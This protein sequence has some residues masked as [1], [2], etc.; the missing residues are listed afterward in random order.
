MTE[1]NQQDNFKKLKICVLHGYL[2]TG[3]GSNIFVGNLVRN[4]C[5]LGHDVYLFCQQTY[6]EELDYIHQYSVF[7]KG[8]LSYRTV[9]T[10]DTPFPGKCYL[11]NPHIN[12][13]LPVYVFDR[14]K[15]FAV[16]TFT[17][18]HLSEVD[19][20]IA[21]NAQAVETVHKE[22]T[23]DLIQSNHA[24][25]SPYIAREVWKKH[26]VPYYI[27]IHGSALNF[28]LKKDSRFMP[29]AESAF[30]DAT[31][32]FAVSSHNRLEAITFFENIAPKI[33]EK[34]KV[35]PAGVD[36]NLFKILKGPKK[37][38]IE[39]LKSQ[40]K[41]SLEVLPYGKTVKQKKDFVAALSQ[42]YSIQEI[43][44]LVFISNQQYEQGHPDQDVIAI[45]D[46][47]DWEN[48]RVILFVGKYLW[49]K[50]VQM[51]ISSLP[52]VLKYVPNVHLVLVGFGSYREELEALSHSL[53]AGRRELFSH[54][55]EK[56]IS[57]LNSEDDPDTA[58]PF[59]FLHTLSKRKKIQEYFDLSAD[60]KISEHV[61]FLGALSHTELSS[62]LPCVDGF[63]AASV[64]PEAFGMVSIEALACGVMPTVSNQTG[65]KE[66]VDLISDTVDTGQ[67]MPR[68][69]VNMD[70]IFTIGTNIIQNIIMSDLQ[71]NRFKKELRQL[72]LDHFS[73]ERIATRYTDFYESDIQELSS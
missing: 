68:I 42:T 61:H 65:F 7:A 63:V 54:L 71:G 30:L 38:S 15:G 27:T 47:I 70:M 72:T 31:K 52:F 58:K 53:Q 28:V 67:E 48:D 19:A 13:L 55:I 4:F 50:G 51:V 40:L 26:K 60:R 32:I 62:L 23:F 44:D 37:H 49:T 16:K 9:F 10:K 39:L 69:D 56:N 5:M 1:E 57:L 2:L 14:Y 36:T 21:N 22:V 66:I 25:I 45:I 59:S 20:H 24:V 3:T 33:E 12:G 17:E 46:K 8:N 35:I 18:M 64:F 29:Y 34:F 6:P 41:E 43:E 11:F 73:W